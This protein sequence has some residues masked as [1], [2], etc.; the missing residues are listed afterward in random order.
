MIDYCADVVLIYF[1]ASTKTIAS[2]ACIHAIFNM[3]THMVQVL[4]REERVRSKLLSP[5]GVAE[6]VCTLH[7]YT[8]SQVLTQLYTAQ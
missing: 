7:I 1:V 2:H 3:Q 8:L 6:Q 4:S 5:I